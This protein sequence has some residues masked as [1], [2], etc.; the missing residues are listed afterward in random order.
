[1]QLTASRQAVADQ[2]RT[3]VG[4]PYRHHGRT[5][6]KACDCIG[7]V[8]GVASELS[9]CP[10][11]TLIAYRPIPPGDYVRAVA[12]TCL[13]RVERGLDALR[14][15]DIALLWCIDQGVGIHF[16]I[17]N[18][19][20]GQKTMIHAFSKPEKVVEHYWDRFWSARFVCAYEYPGMEPV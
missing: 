2:A 20:L 14:P 3:W 18:S 1:M 12:D 5:K 17:T 16:A 9:L 10:L 15:G 7:L 8:L 6:G 19:H 4:T 11:P 13:I